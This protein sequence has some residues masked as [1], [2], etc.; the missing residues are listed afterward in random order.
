M[1][2]DDRDDPFEDLDIPDDREGDPFEKL[3]PPEADGSDDDGAVD[4]ADSETEPDDPAVPTDHSEWEQKTSIPDDGPSVD[5]D[6]PTDS[7][8]DPFS[9][10]DERGGDPFGAGESAFETVDVESIDPDE[11]WA[12]LGETK[13][14]ATAQ[15][16][17]R[18]DEVSKHRYCEQCEFFTGPPETRCTHEDAEIIEFLD[19]ETVRLLNCP[20]VAEQRELGNE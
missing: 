14:E 13:T 6:D 11:V 3:D 19:M 1:S 17:S 9:E 18:Y 16:E 15:R 8:D 7:T 20:I 5:V 2:D 4:D 12:S 10:M